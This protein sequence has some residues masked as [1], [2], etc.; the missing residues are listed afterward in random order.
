MYPV[1]K[2]IDFALTRAKLLD[3][4]LF[5]IIDGIILPTHLFD[6][7]NVELD[8]TYDIHLKYKNTLI[9]NAKYARLYELQKYSMIICSGIY[10]TSIDLSRYYL[11]SYL[12]IPKFCLTSEDLSLVNKIIK[13]IL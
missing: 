6:S 1:S 13:S 8:K 9:Y 4:D 11:Y 10:N 5:T 7:L 3:Y 12:E 2:L